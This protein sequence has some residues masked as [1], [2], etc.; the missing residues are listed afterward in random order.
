MEEVSTG[1]IT[2]KFTIKLVLLF[3]VIDLIIGAI[4]LV[5][6]ANGVDGV[7]SS[8]AKEIFSMLNGLLTKLVIVNIIAIIVP[9]LLATSSIKKKFNIS[10]EQRKTVFRNITIVLVIMAIILFICHKSVVNMVEESATEGSEYSLSDIDKGI[11][12]AEDLAE[13]W[14]LKDDEAEDVFKGWKSFRRLTTL[15]TI[16]AIVFLIMIPVE[17]YLIIKKEQNA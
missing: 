2:R 13:E 10:G 8:S 16:D 17:Y 12:E 9:T 14:N 6:W 1:K 15:Y 3:I 4:V 5:S 11:K 7:D